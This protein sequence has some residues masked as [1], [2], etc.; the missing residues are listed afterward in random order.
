MVNYNIPVKSCF[1]G[2]FSTSWF[3]VTYKKNEGVGKQKTL[4]LQNYL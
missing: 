3:Y 4:E 1:C 2:I